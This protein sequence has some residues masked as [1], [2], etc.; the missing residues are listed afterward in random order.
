MFIHGVF[1]IHT[2]NLHHPTST[3]LAVTSDLP[4]LGLAL[5]HATAAAGRGGGARGPRGGGRSN[6]IQ[7]AIRVD[8]GP[9]RPNLGTG[10]VPS[11]L[12]PLEFYDLV[13]RCGKSYYRISNETFESE[14]L[15]ALWTNID[16]FMALSR[17]QRVQ[18]LWS[19]VYY[20]DLSFHKSQ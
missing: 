5:V 4:V 13:G 8:R 11:T 9:N 12:N 16:Q 17:V 18:I 20:K 2:Y 7:W 3:R 1:G 15:L 6:R 19:G 14:I 10:T